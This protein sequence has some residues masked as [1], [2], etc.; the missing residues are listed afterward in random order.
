MFI[1]GNALFFCLISTSIC[2]DLCAA[3]DLFSLLNGIA[4][5]LIACYLIQGVVK[6]YLHFDVV[7][8]SLHLR[9]RS[10]ANDCC[11]DE[12]CPEECTVLLVNADF[13][14]YNCNL[15]AVPA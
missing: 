1:D 11:I 4:F 3:V 13:P 6:M 8:L 12:S 10:H 5:E 2:F 9:Y 15:L 14:S 7:I